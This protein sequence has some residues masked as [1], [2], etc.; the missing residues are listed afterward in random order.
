[1]VA[2]RSASLRTLGGAIVVAAVLIVTGDRVYRAGQGALGL[3]LY[4]AAGLSPAIALGARVAQLRRVQ[5]GADPEGAAAATAALRW[6]RVALALSV[7]FA[8]LVGWAM[9]Y[10]FREGPPPG[11]K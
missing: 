5:G 9:W 7:A 4:V 6:M 8:V 1:M 10:L 3:V 11:L 2:Y